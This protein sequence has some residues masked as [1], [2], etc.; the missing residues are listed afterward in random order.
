MRLVTPMPSLSELIRDHAPVL[1]LDAASLRSQ[2]GLYAADGSSRWETQ[3]GEAGVA[4]FRCVE[5]LDVDL[6]T[7]RAFV[8][9]EGPGSTLGI[10]TVAMALRA[11][12]T[13]SPRPAYA[14]GSLDLIAHA[15]GAPATGIIA[16]ARRDTWHYQRLGQPL[17]RVPTA[18]LPLPTDVVTTPYDVAA[19]L[20]RTTEAAIFRYVE[21]PEAF[22]HEEPSYATWSPHIH[23]A[24]TPSA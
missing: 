21:A 8:F 4:I 9:C 20:A 14:Y 5:R 22:L 1:I 18:E 19:L 13:L 2:V 6:A 17:R 10:R 15:V 16:D 7:V 12:Q 11:W 3:T 24:P 23:R